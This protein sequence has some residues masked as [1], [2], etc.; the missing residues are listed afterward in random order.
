MA[1]GATGA[2]STNVGDVDGMVPWKTTFLDEQGVNSTSMLVSRSV[3]SHVKNIDM[4]TR[5]RP[6]I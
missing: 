2:A 3:V 4:E 6:L 1:S 5:C